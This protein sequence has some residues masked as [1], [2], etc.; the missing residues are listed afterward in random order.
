MSISSA[1]Y[2]SSMLAA[3]GIDN[4]CAGAADRFP[5]VELEDVAS[6]DVDVVLAPSE[7]YAFGERHVAELEA[8]APVELIDGQDLFWWGLRTPAALDRL[9]SRLAAWR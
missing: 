4:V 1:T 3:L 9:A 7:P 6:R 5:T 8:I 2:G